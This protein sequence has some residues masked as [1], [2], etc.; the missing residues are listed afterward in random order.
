MLRGMPRQ[1]VKGDD[2]DSDEAVL[3]E[4][5]TKGCTFRIDTF[6]VRLKE[7]DFVL[8]QENGWCRLPQQNENQT[9]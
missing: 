7:R 9:F 2:S 1:K 6:K 8:T 3:R 5:K 4:V